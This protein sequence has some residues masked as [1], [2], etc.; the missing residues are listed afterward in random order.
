MFSLLLLSGKSPEVFA[1]QP[2]ADLV[3]ACRQ[4]GV[5]REGLELQPVA[6][7]EEPMMRPLVDDLRHAQTQ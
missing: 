2:D 7:Q 1:G 4:V 3:V 5:C 6:P